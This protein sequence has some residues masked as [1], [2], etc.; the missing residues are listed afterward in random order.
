MGLLQRKCACG[1]HLPGGG[2]CADCSRKRLQR[3]CGDGAA[4]AAIPPIVH[5][6]L[7]SDGK[8]LDVGVQ[9]LMESRFGRDFS[10]VRVH[11]DSTAA[12]SAQA[13]NAEAYT[14][15]RDIVFAPGNY[16]PQTPSGLRLLA[17]EMA[18]VVQAA[19][20]L[21]SRDALSQ[22]GDPL[23]VAAD[24]AAD[25]VMEGR[26]VSMAARAGGHSGG[27]MRRVAARST[28]CA[29]N[30]HGAPADPLA[31]LTDNDAKAMDFAT[32][33]AH[34][35]AADAQTARSGIPAAPSTTFQS[36]RTHFG[37]PA[38]Q[39]RGFLNRLTGV[40]RPTQG[41]AMG[42][43]LGILS[44]R[45]ALVARLYSQPMNYVCVDRAGVRF[46]GCESGA[47]TGRNG[48]DAWSCAGSGVVFLCPSFWSA[49]DSDGRAGI[50]MHE[51]LH[52]NFEGV[53]DETLRGPGRNFKIAGCYEAISNEVLGINSAF[54]CPAPP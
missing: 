21:K 24:A 38:A 23:E 10:H 33:L 13:V 19:S 18:H 4:G 30:T 20:G 32:R 42:E 3:K 50:L 52:V 54:S 51:A 25:A 9:T 28:H 37:L 12:A 1:T 8:P 36:Y 2:E 41:V 15:G 5:D 29:A 14:D 43:E 17:H 34:A 53:G 11:T 7:R 46:G 22:P 48:G 31:E 44:R 47:C 49:Y 45:F 6:A 35:L 27:I 26:R 16:A 39:G 40:V